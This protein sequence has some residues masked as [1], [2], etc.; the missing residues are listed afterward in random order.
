MCVT[1]RLSFAYC[2]HA[3]LIYVSNI[4]I[5][6]VCID[7]WRERF[8]IRTPIAED[9][10]A[11]CTLALC[12]AN[13]PAINELGIITH[14]LAVLEDEEDQGVL[15]DD[16][17]LISTAPQGASAVKASTAHESKG[18]QDAASSRRVKVQI[19]ETDS[20]DDDE[21]SSSTPTTGGQG[22]AACESHEASNDAPQAGTK[23]APVP[24]DAQG[25]DEQLLTEVKKIKEE[26]DT[27]FKKSLFDKAAEAY[28]AALQRL[29]EADEY[30][31]E[32]T[33][34]Y[35]NRAACR[36]QI[37]DFPATIADCNEVLGV[38]SD[39]VKALVRR[40]LSYE[41]LERYALLMF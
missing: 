5:I 20:D 26:G 28:S 2:I 30:A 9:R 7:V 41:N 39:N 13:I 1:F 24:W 33:V 27:L 40:G 31:C 14:F 19:V 35:N 3:S 12:D 29:G 8:D 16:D 22:T 18:A 25:R 17:T 37:R 15:I 36:F 11:R 6:V 34:C 23:V 32:R 10:V 38:D 21:D 4:T